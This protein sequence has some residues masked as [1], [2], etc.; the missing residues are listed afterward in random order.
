ML[1]FTDQT[2]HTIRLGKIPNRI[3]SI[4]PSQ[5][6]LLWDLGLR[7][8]LV[9][10][11]KFCIHPDEMFTRVTRVGGTKKLNIEKIRE[12]K[13]DLIIGNKE[14]NER[15]EIEMLRKE[16]NVWMSDIFNFEDALNMMKSLGEITGK[17]AEAEK[18]INRIKS[19]LPSVKNI[20]SGQKV[21]YFIWKNPYMLAASNTFIDH[22][23]NFTGFKNA[24]AGLSRYPEISIEKLK[25]LKPDFCFLSS[26][27]FPF[28]EIHVNELQEQLPDS[29][30]MIADGEI[31]SWY[32][33]RL[34]HLPAYL[35]KLGEEIR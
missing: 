9:G 17:T 27:P 26:E 5:S 1:T 34:L 18:I 28:K 35:K 13:P 6:E 19:D 12:L 14:E 2:A 32:G 8:A 10:I 4:V 31:F 33:S 24:A 11:T 20:F 30:V 25:E 22:V 23:L 7:E 16:F 15:Q 29:K 3:I 21:A